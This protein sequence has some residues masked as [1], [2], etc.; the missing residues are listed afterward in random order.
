MAAVCMT[1]LDMYHAVGGIRTAERHALCVVRPCYIYHVFMSVW[2][3]RARLVPG[4][5]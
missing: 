1:P 2:H 3:L 5:F 4:L